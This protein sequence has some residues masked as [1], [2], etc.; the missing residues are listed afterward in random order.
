MQC[1]END[2]DEENYKE[3]TETIMNE[4]DC[5]NNSDSLF[6]YETIAEKRYFQEHAW[7]NLEEEL[8]L[9]SDK[10]EADRKKHRQL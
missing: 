8:S 1:E 6:K 2:F 4:F 10:L 7:D 3:I 5:K 9:F